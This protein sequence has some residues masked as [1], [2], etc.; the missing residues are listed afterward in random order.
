MPTSDLNTTAPNTS[1]SSRAKV[2]ESGERESPEAPRSQASTDYRAE[3]FEL[4]GGSTADPTRV[5]EDAAH[6]AA[7]ELDR[8]Q[9]YLA[10]YVPRTA[11]EEKAAQL[12]RGIGSRLSV[13]LRLHEEQEQAEEAE[14]SSPPQGA[15]SKET[16]DAMAPT[17]C[18]D[19]VESVCE[20]LRAQPA[21]E[22]SGAMNPETRAVVMRV[23]NLEYYDANSSAHGGVLESVLYNAILD[24]KA[25]RTAVTASDDREIAGQELENMF[26]SLLGRIEAGLEVAGDIGRETRRTASPTMSR[27]ELA[28]A[29]RAYI[30]VEEIQ[31]SGNSLFGAPLPDE[32]REALITVVDLEDSIPTP[33]AF[34]VHSMNG[35]E[36]E[37]MDVLL[38]LD[39]HSPAWRSLGAALAQF[40]VRRALL[41]EL[42]QRQGSEEDA[43]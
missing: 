34:A 25:L 8:V 43:A 19:D 7:E 5:L 15:P 40:R 10:D 4:V 17:L 27:D 2:P 33:L 16:A 42:R 26:D 41:N 28:D 9:E 14:V 29:L 38:E 11:K 18:P 23:L 30:R 39:E 35:L 31:E 20:A 32:L 21:S 13:A 6:Q 36:Y 22:R 12:L 37:V 24:L 3:A 1:P